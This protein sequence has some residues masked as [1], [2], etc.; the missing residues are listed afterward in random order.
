MR[1]KL[2]I[3][4]IAVGLLLV[5][6]A[7]L[8]RWVVAPAVAVLP[9]STDTTRTY[10]GTATQLLNAAALTS[11]GQALLTDVPIT[12]VHHTK[13]LGTHGKN[14][15]VSDARTVK[16]GGQTV[17]GVDYR[18]A[19]NRT[20]LGAGNGYSGVVKQTGLTFNWPIRTQKHDYTGWVPDTQTTTRL[21]YTGTATR[22]GV[23]TYVY[24]ANT[25]AAPIKDPQ[26]LSA[27]PTS[28]PKAT[29]VTLVSGLG[30]SADQQ[31]A[32]QQL[33]PTLPDPVKF[34]FT[35]QVAAT[36]WVAPASGIV[37]D[38]KEHEVRTI[39]LATGPLT[40]P[41]AAVMD[42]TFTSTPATLA[43]AA[44]DARD[45]GDAVSLVYVTLPVALAAGGGLLLVL[46]LVGLMLGRRR[47]PTPQPLPRELTPVG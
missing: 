24:T 3:V 18:Y 14:A 12:V 9:G 30:L 20:D 19:V 29:V 38:L 47:P 43:A 16:A 1:K 34:A 41:V 45:K 10:S 39:A 22:G 37:V 40:V 17:A 25:T 15:L 33:L 2:S 27:L 35:Y 42:I 13:V 7:G 44:A 11:G 6:G 4:G 28:L 31:K 23:D 26:V 8:M 32:F 36:Y 21:N 46:G 5:L